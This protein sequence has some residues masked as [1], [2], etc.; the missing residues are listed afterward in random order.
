MGKR[1]IVTDLER[2]QLLGFKIG[3]SLDLSYLPSRNSGKNLRYIQP[4]VLHWLL[5]D[6]GFFHQEAPQWAGLLDGP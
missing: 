3:S 1:R 4:K 2:F 6:L 5:A